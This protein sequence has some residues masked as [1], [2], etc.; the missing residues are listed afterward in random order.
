MNRKL[1]LT[2]SIFLTTILS[3]SAQTDSLNTLS[4]SLITN[5]LP[6]GKSTYLVYIQDSEDGPKYKTEI[7]ERA[8][9]RE[10]DYFQFSWRRN[11]PDKT[12]YDYEITAK[13]ENFDPISEIVVEHKEANGD[14][15][16]LRKHYLYQNQKLLTHTDTSQHNAAPFQLDDLEH[17]FNWE[18]DMETFSMLPF[19]EGKVFWIKF[20][21]PGSK[22]PPKYYKYEV[23]RSETLSFNGEPHD[24]WVL[25]IEYSKQLWTEFW[26]DKTTFRTLKMKEAFF[27][28]YRFKMLVI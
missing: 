3:V 25:K 13:T 23:D 14:S 1:V 28:R 15:S 20:Y 12:F 16:P 2:I 26:I 10:D 21:H 18:M 4:N 7:W 22:T 11:F 8:I 24:C 5:Q 6:F 17:S 9:K 27:G 19:A